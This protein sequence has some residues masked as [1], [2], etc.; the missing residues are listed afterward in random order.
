MRTPGTARGCYYEET[1]SGTPL[2]FVHEFAGDH[3]SWEPQVRFFARCYRC[4]AYD[5]RGYPAFRRAARTPSA[6]RRRAPRD[7]IRAVLD[8]PEDRPAR[9]SS[10][11]R[12]AASPR[13]TSA[14]PIPKRARSLVVAGCGYGAEPSEKEKFR[15]ECR[16]RRRSSSSEGMAKRRSDLR[17]GPTRVQFQNKDPRG[18]AEFA[19]QLAE[20][21]AKGPALHHARRADAPAVALR[22]D[23]GLKQISV[24]V[25][26]VT[27]DEDDPC[28]EPAL[29]MK[30]TI[31]T[32]GLLVL[33]RAGHAINIEE[34]DAFNRA[35]FEFFTLVDEGRAALRDPRSLASGILGYKK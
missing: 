23:R 10:A 25:L 33:P 1:G 27:G 11:C 7:D 5:A 34:P 29:L 13:C 35:L 30:R 14:S 28:L 2:V 4:I 15:D 18:W 6:T 21:S 26:I 31:P 20:H 3:R 8:A 19:S 32:R 12:W 17:L 16:G 24:P 9:T 22:A